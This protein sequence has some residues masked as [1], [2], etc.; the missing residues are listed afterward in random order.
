MG[1][2]ERDEI[3]ETDEAVEALF[4]TKSDRVRKRQSDFQANASYGLSH[5]KKVV[6]VREVLR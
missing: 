5:P 4:S 3:Y 6:N 1:L 2:R